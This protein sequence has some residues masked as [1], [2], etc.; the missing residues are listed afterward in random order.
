MRTVTVTE[1]RAT[2]SNLLDA[3]ARGEQITIT[4]Y[5]VPVAM[6]APPIKPNPDRDAAIEAF[7]NGSQGITLGGLSIREMIEEGRP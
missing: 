3:T 4:R 7:R 2:W 6:L 1:A 5:S